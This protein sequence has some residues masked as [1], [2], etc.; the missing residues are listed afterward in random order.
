[1]PLQLIDTKDT[2]IIKRT[3]NYCI[4]MRWLGNRQ[5]YGARLQER[6]A[7]GTGM[8]LTADVLGLIKKTSFKKNF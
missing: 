2:K 7:A 8:L 3:N 6:G 1:V 4:Y 5:K